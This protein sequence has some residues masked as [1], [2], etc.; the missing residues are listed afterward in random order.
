MVTRTTIAYKFITIT[1]MGGP[2]E[3]VPPSPSYRTEVTLWRLHL[4]FYD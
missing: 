2:A 4:F 1:A 3:A